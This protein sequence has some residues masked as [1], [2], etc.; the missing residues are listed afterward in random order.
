MVKEKKT[1]KPNIVIIQQRQQVGKTEFKPF[2]H[3]TV[4]AI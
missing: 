4:E 2:F 3:R 1:K